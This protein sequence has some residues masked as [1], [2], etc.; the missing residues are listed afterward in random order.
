MEE[1]IQ[2]ITEFLPALLQ[3]LGALVI[4]ATVIVRVTPSKTDDETVG[5]IGQALFKVIKY[6]PTLGVNPRTKK[7]EEAYEELRAKNG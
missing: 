1:T 5:K 3:V 6:L 2:N 7:L 4:A